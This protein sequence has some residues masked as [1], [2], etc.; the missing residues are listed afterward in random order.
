MA[1]YTY[2]RF[3]DVKAAMEDTHG[4][5]KT[6]SSWLITNTKVTTEVFDYARCVGLDITAWYLPE[7]KG[8]RNLIINSGLHP[9][10][11]LYQLSSRHISQLVDRGLVTCVRVKEAIENDTVRD[12]FTAEQSQMLLKDISSFCK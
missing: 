2:A 10:T 7:G 6:Y 1:L 11:V 4:V 12:I 3:L 9:V 8:L 5:A